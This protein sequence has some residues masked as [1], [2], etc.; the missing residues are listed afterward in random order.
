MNVAVGFVLFSTFVLILL[1]D[2]DEAPQGHGVFAY[3]R[4]AKADTK[5]DNNDKLARNVYYA[6]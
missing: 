3:D 1:G 2:K 5:R 4:A 6:S